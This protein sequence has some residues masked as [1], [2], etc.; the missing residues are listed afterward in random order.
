MKNIIFLMLSCLLC[1]PVC[2]QYEDDDVGYSKVKKESRT[3]GNRLKKGNRNII[4]ASGGKGT[5]NF[6]VWSVN[7][8][9][10]HQFNPYVFLG[11]GVSPRFYKDLFDK[12]AQYYNF[13]EQ[14]QMFAIPIFAN[15][16]SDFIDKKITPFVDLKMGYSPADISGFY[17]SLALGCRFCIGNVCN[18]SLSTGIESQNYNRTEVQSIG[19]SYKTKG[20]TKAATD[21]FLRIG[22]DL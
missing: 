21:Y 12:K 5:E 19:L 15:L 22:M 18:L 20:V 11:L 13:G 14:E 2:A 8:T 10:G 7:L 16:R 9:T 6:S 4:E 3:T 1:L 17:F